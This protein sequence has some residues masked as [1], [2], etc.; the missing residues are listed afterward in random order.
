MTSVL[1]SVPGHAS[2]LDR[3]ERF[4][5]V[6]RI[7]TLAEDKGRERAFRASL[8]AAVCWRLPPFV[9]RKG[10]ERGNVTIPVL[11]QTRSSRLQTP[12]PTG[13]EAIP[14]AVYGNEDW[15]SVGIDMVRRASRRG[16]LSGSG[17]RLDSPR[18]A[19][20]DPF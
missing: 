17:S 12:A 9:A 6:R 16:P 18:I 15:V 19:V 4:A 11:R 8:C 2:N 10:Q 13:G 20:P 7:L 5:R 1:R 3:W 14:Y